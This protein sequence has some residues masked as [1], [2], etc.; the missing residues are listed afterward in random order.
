MMY[1]LQ[2]AKKPLKSKLTP[3]RQILEHAKHMRTY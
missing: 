1:Q 2:E 3:G